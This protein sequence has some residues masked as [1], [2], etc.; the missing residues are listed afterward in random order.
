MA[1][2]LIIFLFVFLYFFSDQKE[3]KI[4]QVILVLI[5]AII[6]FIN[7]LLAWKKE[8][9]GGMLFVIWGFLYL[10]INLSQPTKPGWGYVVI[11]IWVVLVGLLF[12]LDAMLK[13]GEEIKA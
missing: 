13:E 11:P 1:F 10:A 6:I 3:I 12:S 4:S 2:L 9:I 8:L 5:P 7:T